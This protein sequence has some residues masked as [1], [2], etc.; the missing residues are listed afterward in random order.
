MLWLTL[1]ITIVLTTIIVWAHSW[2]LKNRERHPEFFKHRRAIGMVLVI[3]FN[4]GDL[5]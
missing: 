3:I 1:L 4:L 5:F 2:I